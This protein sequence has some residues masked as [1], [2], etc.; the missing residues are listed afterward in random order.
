MNGLHASLSSKV[1]TYVGSLRQC[2]AFHC[3][4]LFAFIFPARGMQVGPNDAV[5]IV[6]KSAGMGSGGGGLA[7]VVFYVSPESTCARMPRIQSNFGVHLCCIC[8]VS[9]E[10][11]VDVETKGQRFINM[12]DVMLYRGGAFDYIVKGAYIAGLRPPLEHPFELNRFHRVANRALCS[13]RE[14]AQQHLALLR[15]ECGNDVQCTTHSVARR[16]VVSSLGF[17]PSLARRSVSA[18]AVG[19][20]PGWIDA[21]IGEAARLGFA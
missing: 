6:K 5:H 3:I 12:L 17:R 9:D 19:L 15:S 11:K 1:A 18:A 14:V 7:S 20:C 8:F 10:F 13:F 21:R 4:M 16:T 2:H